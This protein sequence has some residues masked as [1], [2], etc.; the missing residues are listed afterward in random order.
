MDPVEGAF[1][2]I[3]TALDALAYVVDGLMA[4][5]PRYWKHSSLRF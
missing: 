1:W 4:R 5:K 2:M 3:S